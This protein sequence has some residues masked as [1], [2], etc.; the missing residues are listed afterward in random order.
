MVQT[1]LVFSHYQSLRGW[2]KISM[3]K[4]SDTPRSEAYIEVRRSDEG[5]E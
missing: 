1:L 2:W 4:A 5:W 3:C